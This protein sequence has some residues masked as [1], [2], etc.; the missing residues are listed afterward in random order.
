MRNDFFKYLLIHGRKSVESETFPMTFKA[1]R[2]EN[3]KNYRI[4]GNTV[5][6]ESVGDRT[7]NLFDE[8]YTE[9]TVSLVTHY[10]EL[11]V[12]N[13]Q[14]TLST[15]TPLAG[16]VANLFLCTT[17]DPTPNTANNGAYKDSPKTVTVNDERLFIFYR[18]LNADPRDYQTMLNLGSTALPYEPYGYKIPVTLTANTS[19]TTDIYLNA[20]LAKSGNNADY[21]DFK[22]QKR[23]NSDG[24]VEDMTVPEIAVTTGTNTLTIGTE[25]QPSKIYLQGHISRGDNNAE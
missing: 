22:T 10:R 7:E 6:G 5:N 21:I 24:T 16:V 17:E 15:S 13:G 25:V 3:L 8:I 11:R 18:A 19:E 20:P 9:I 14:Y 2:T 1:K 4:Y 12:P 23:Y